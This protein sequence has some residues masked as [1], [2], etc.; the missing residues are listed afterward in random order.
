MPINNGKRKAIL[1]GKVEKETRK[2]NISHSVFQ[3][4]GREE[5][6][7]LSILPLLPLAR[8]ETSLCVVPRD[9]P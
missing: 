9:P 2:R 1:A 3:N 7:N 4:G 6:L 8:R 5:C